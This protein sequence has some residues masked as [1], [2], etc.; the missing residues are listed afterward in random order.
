MDIKENLFTNDF[1]KLL[2]SSPT[3]QMN[4]CGAY[5]T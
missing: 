1:A 5:G 2:T 3:D 4:G